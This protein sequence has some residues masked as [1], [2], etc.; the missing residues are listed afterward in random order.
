VL[1]VSPRVSLVV[2]VF[3]E[4]ALTRAFLDSLRATTDP[5]HLVVIDNGSTDG[6]GQ[7]FERF[8]YPFPLTYE[9][10]AGNASV[11]ASL[12]R[13]WRLAK[14]EFVC[15][16]HNDTQMITPD[17]LGRLLRPFTV[18]AVGLTGLFGA[19]RV[20]RTA[21][22]AGHTIVHSLA[23]GPTVRPPWEEVAVIDSV[24]MCLPRDLLEGVGGLD[25][26]LGFQHGYDKDLS[27]AV[28]ERRRRCLVVHAPFRH[29][30]GGTRT[31]D[32]DDQPE[33]AHE[34]LDLRKAAGDRLVAKWRHRLPCDV[35]PL[36]QRA[37]EWMA[38]R[39]G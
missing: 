12:N 25:E 7:L 2:A 23:E 14:T 27:L 32:F 34:D 30:G 5:F 28:R 13:A 24:C 19:K 1:G 21:S 39:L 8:P 29:R 36:G 20:R 22:F 16:V 3:N 9:P 6:T 4:L 37:R 10:Q 11:I 17:W 18:P 33:R 15:F 31:R 38:T 35:R 26:S